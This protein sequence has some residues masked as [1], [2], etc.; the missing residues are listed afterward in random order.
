MA[1]S[2]L[3]SL[4]CPS[5][6]T[7]HNPCYAWELEWPFVESISC[8]FLC[9]RAWMA[10]RLELLKAFAMLLNLD[11]PSLRSFHGPCYALELGLVLVGSFSWHLLFLGAC[12]DLCWEFLMALSMIVSLNGPS[13]GDSHGPCYAWELGCPLGAFHGLCYA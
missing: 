10:L 4:D 2:M 13:F 3:E 8:S 9:L 5:L 12:M 11:G 7:F 6:G 1:L